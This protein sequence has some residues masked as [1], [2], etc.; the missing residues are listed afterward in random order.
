V[1]P[2]GV[3]QAPAHLPGWKVLASVVVLGVAGTALAYLLFF[4]LIAGAGAHYAALVTYLV[5]P[6]ALV[7][8]AIFLG[9]GI[10]VAALAGL[11][12]ILGGV[13]LGTRSPREPQRRERRVAVTESP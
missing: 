7:Y 1:L 13:A 6:V 4:S 9:E 8:G 11:V 12:L 10:G 2:A 3:A 5:P